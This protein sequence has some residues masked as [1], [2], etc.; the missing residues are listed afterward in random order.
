M[1]VDSQSRVSIAVASILAAALNSAYAQ[2]KPSNS[3]PVDEVTVTGTFIRQ[4]E[5]FT[6]ASPVAEISRADF[7]ANAPKTVA[8]FLTTLPYSFNSTF[9]VGRAL[10]SSNG[11]GSIN[12]RNLG[13][14][15]T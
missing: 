8:D 14:D 5:G 1:S 15:A 13:A 10:G 4:S 11:S 9:T 3:T 7:E 2:E 12:L 6:P